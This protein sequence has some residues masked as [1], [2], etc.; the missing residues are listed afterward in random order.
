MNTPRLTQAQLSDILVSKA[1]S[2]A[3]TYKMFTERGKSLLEITKLK[4]NRR[5]GAP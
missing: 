4:P 3:E 5:D 1:K 2:K